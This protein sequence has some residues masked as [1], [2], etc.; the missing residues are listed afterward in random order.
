MAPGSTS[1][2]MSYSSDLQ[3]VSLDGFQDQELSLEGEGSGM[4]PT[5]SSK[6]RNMKMGIAVLIVAAVAATV[7]VV[8]ASVHQVLSTQGEISPGVGPAPVRGML[9]CSWIP[10]D[11]CIQQDESACACRRQNPRGPCSTCEGYGGSKCRTPGGCSRS[12]DVQPVAGHTTCGDPVDTTGCACGWIHDTAKCH[13][14]GGRC[15][16]ACKNVNQGCFC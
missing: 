1:P 3:D 4:L 12:S 10:Y 6:K 2:A 16:D 8:G 14:T 13:N 5:P 15:F 7:A 9:D 11:N